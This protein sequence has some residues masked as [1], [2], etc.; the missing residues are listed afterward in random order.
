VG[1]GAVHG[2]LDWEE[3]A[4]LD[5]IE[6][7][8]LVDRSHRKLSHRGSYTGTVFVSPLTVLRVALNPEHAVSA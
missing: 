2:I 4:I 8:G 7:W 3:Q 1:R 6:T 5:P